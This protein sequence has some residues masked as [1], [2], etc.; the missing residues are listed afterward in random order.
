MDSFLNDIDSF[1]Y[2]LGICLLISVIF[3]ADYLF[4]IGAFLVVCVMNITEYL[5]VLCLRAPRAD[6]DAIAQEE[7]AEPQAV[8]NNEN[9]EQNA[10]TENGQAE[11]EI[12][13][14]D[15]EARY[16]FHREFRGK[17][18]RVR[19]QKFMRKPYEILQ[20]I[21]KSAEADLKKQWNEACY[22]CFRKG[23]FDGPVFWEIQIADVAIS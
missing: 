14:M 7:L 5:R 22:N 16:V 18:L 4:H 20:G 9:E 23:E 12:V 21:E 13:E 1:P 10:A 19:G 8:V 11:D 6:T 17:Y 3:I 15:N 2:F